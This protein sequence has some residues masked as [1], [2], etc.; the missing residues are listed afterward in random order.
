MKQNPEGCLSGFCYCLILPSISKGLHTPH[1][2]PLWYALARLF[3]RRGN[4][5]SNFSLK[6][7]LLVQI[8]LQGSHVGVAAELQHGR[9]VHAVLLNQ[10]DRLRD[11]SMA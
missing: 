2:D 10:P 4:E 8:I 6:A 11:G 5:V 3:G 9:Q 7:S 1:N